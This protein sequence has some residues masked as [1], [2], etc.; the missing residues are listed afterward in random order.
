MT[1]INHLSG[2]NHNIDRIKTSN[3]SAGAEP[4]KSVLETGGGKDTVSFSKNQTEKFDAVFAEFSK[5]VPDRTTTIPEKELAISY[6]DRM[7]ACD[8]IP[9]DLKTYWQNKKSIIQQEIQAIRNEEKSGSGEKVADVWKEFEKFCNKY[10]GK[11]DKNLSTEDRSEYLITYNRTCQSYLKRLMSCSDITDDLRFEYQN[12]YQN[13]END[14][15]N[16]KRDMLNARKE[17]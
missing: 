5:N 15:N 7:L 13:H 16:A 17:K 14:L 10:R 9:D 6:I 2:F 1:F 8:D 12:M 3:A 4:A 11:F